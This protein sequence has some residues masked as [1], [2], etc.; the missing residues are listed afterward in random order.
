LQ[1]SAI[2]AEIMALEAKY[3]GRTHLVYAM[4]VAETLAEHLP[5]M[6][7]FT[8]CPDELNE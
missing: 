7:T 8:F 1:A 5:A 3:K 4:M 2:E 6:D